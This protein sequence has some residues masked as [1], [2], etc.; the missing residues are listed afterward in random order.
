MN[1]VTQ[2]VMRIFVLVVISFSFIGVVSAENLTINETITTNETEKEEAVCE[3]QLEIAIEEYNSLLKDFQK[4]INCGEVAVF[5]RGL[6]A[7]LAKERDSCREEIGKI[8]IYRVGF[9]IL[10]GILTITAI[11]MIIFSVIKKE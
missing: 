2:S 6:N 5:N 9:Y 8:K 1:K 3:E 10:L 11:I 4:G 7:M